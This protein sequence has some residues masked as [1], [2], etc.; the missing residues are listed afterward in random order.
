M[1]C[2]TAD[3]RLSHGSHACA[4]RGY[5]VAAAEAA[6]VEL[7]LGLNE[8]AFE[9]H[10]PHYPDPLVAPVGTVKGQMEAGPGEWMP[11]PVV[12]SVVLVWGAAQEA[13]RMREGA[14]EALVAA[15]RGLR[16]GGWAQMEVRDLLP[17]RHSTFVRV[18]PPSVY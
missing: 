17:P 6:A 4:Q 11:H 14:D 15:M 13:A 3:V 2:Q 1:L 9:A 10:L 18:A 5:L 16:E 7:D 8:F 12:H